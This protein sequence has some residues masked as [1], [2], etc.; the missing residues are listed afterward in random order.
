MFK[1]VILFLFLYSFF[2]ITYSQDNAKIIIKTN[3]NIIDQNSSFE[4]VVEMESTSESINFVDKI[5]WIENFG[6]ISNANSSQTSIING[7]FLN[8]VS[9]FYSLKPIKK[10]V[11]VIWPAII[12]VNWKTIES[13]S[14]KILVKEWNKIDNIQ[15]INNF[16]KRENFSNSTYIGSLLNTMFSLRFLL[17]IFWIFLF[18]MILFVYRRL[19]TKHEWI[20][21]SIEDN[22]IDEL[23]WISIDDEDFED[24]IFNYL[25]KYIWAKISKNIDNLSFSDFKIIV[26]EKF[27]NKE[28]NEIIDILEKFYYANRITDR[29]KLKKLIST[30]KI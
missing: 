14:I 22:N 9:Q 3:K 5:E 21:L 6:I 7:N 24:K 25:K 29:E 13:N 26:L 2:A 23:I 30:L 18:V 28:L 1:K 15:V 4:L 20:L 10:W 16:S 19:D 11:L 8:K 27:K 12:N 17:I